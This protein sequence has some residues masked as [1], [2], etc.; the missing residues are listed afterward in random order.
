VDRRLVEAAQTGDRDAY[1]QLA[2][3]ISDRL[4]ALALRI[5]RDPDGASDALQLALVRI[6]R[7]LPDLRDPDRFEAWSYR[8]AVRCC[9]EDR[10]RRRHTIRL[11]DLPVEPAAPDSQ[12]A[13]ATRDELERAFASLTHDQRAILVLLYYHDRSVDDIAEIL[14]ISPGTVKSRLHYARNAMRAAIDAGSRGTMEVGRS[15]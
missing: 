10:R 3:L 11:T 12:T 2:R 8:I 1:A 9:Q 6:W 5:V 15:A 13:I 4:Y 14:E 7:D